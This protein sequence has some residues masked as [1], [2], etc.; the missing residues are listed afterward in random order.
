MAYLLTVLHPPLFHNASPLLPLDNPCL[1]CGIG[2]PWSN[3]EVEV[4][5]DMVHLTYVE[6]QGFIYFYFMPFCVGDM[7]FDFNAVMLLSNWYGFI[8]LTTNDKADWKP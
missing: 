2:W 3:G 8:F 7:V 6:P 5:E 1:G 4:W